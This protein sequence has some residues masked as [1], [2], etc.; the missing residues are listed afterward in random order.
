MSG[1]GA[2]REVEEVVED[3]AGEEHGARMCRDS[4][5]LLRSLHFIL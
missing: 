3:E 4:H 1:R 2:C 5:A